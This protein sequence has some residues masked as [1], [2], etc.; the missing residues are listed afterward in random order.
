M[1]PKLFFSYFLLKSQCIKS[2]LRLR[3]Q[4]VPDAISSYVRNGFWKD[5]CW[6]TR[7]PSHG[8]DAGIIS[9]WLRAIAAP[10]RLWFLMLAAW[11]AWGL[12]WK[13]S[14]PTADCWVPAPPISSAVSQLMTAMPPSPDGLPLPLRDS[15]QPQCCVGG[16]Q[17]LGF[18]HFY[19]LLIVGPCYL[20]PAISPRIILD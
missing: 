19:A 11:S 6:G 8:T 2:S 17:R 9:L 10:S 20:S 3:S 1:D 7:H 15:L 16:P 4:Q 5:Y 13:P 12:L 18:S 14:H